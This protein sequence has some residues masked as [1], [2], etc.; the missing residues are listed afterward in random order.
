M[1]KAWTC[2]DHPQ[3]GSF[4]QRGLDEL[5]KIE[6]MQPANQYRC[7][8]CLSSGMYGRL[9]SATAAETADLVARSH[10]EAERSSVTEGV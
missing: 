4:L 9:R 7:P 6:G 3:H 8:V 5:A 10:T 2:L 1:S